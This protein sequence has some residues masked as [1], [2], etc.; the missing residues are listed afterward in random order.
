MSDDEVDNADGWWI[1]LK[2]YVGNRVV[3]FRTCREDWEAMDEDQ[4][5]GELFDAAIELG[6]IP[7]FEYEVDEPASSA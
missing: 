4:R 6:W 2:V 7:D 3:R 1:N 5:Q